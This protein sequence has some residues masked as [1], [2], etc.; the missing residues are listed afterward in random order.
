[1]AERVVGAL[2]PAQGVESAGAVTYHANR[3][4]HFVIA[5][6]VEGEPVLFLVD[7]GASDVVLSPADAARL[8]FDLNTLDYSNRYRT[9]N[10]IGQGAPVVLAQVALG[11]IRLDDVQASVNLAAMDVSLL[12]MSFLSRLAGYEVAGERLTLRP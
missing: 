4:G 2:D 10:G 1:M 3:S 8:G 5:A 6:E 12:G 11:P 7:T 9:A